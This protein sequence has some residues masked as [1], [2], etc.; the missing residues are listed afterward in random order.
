M[1][2]VECPKLI[3]F[4]RALRVSLIDFSGAKAIVSPT[5]R[6]H[7]FLV[8]FFHPGKNE[9]HFAKRSDYSQSMLK[10]N[11]GLSKLH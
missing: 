9:Y 6:S 5:L 2:E 7:D 10:T 1:A 3:M 8:R 11:R 4:E